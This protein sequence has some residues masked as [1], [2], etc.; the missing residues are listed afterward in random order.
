VLLT[1]AGPATG[2]PPGEVSSYYLARADPRLCPSPMCGGLWVTLVNRT[3]T[4]CGDGTRRKECYAAEADL[5]ALPVDE[6]SRVL[7]ARAIVEGR[8]LA[9]GMLVSGRVEAFPELATLVVSE[10]WT[11]SSSQNRGRGVFHKLR[12][13]GVRCITTPC[14]SVHAAAL[15]SGRHVNVSEIDLTPSGAPARER[16]SALQHLPHVGLITTGRVVLDHNAGPAG[17]GRTIVATQFYA[18]GD[19]G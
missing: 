2:D 7:L 17:P 14:F 9:R 19:T 3:R 11:A 4:T 16:R 15:N 12:D 18:R 5:T 13:R 6:K 1:G 8:A 10:V